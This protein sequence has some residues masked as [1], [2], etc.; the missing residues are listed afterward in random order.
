MELQYI[1]TTG[2]NE[3]FIA[4]TKLLDDFVI[5]YDKEE[6]D[7]FA[8]FNGS[9]AIQYALVVYYNNK[10]IGCG[11]IKQYNNTTFEIKRMFVMD[12]YRGKSI[13]VNILQ[14]LEDWATTMKGT[15]C[16]LETAIEFTSAQV[17]YKKMGYKIIPNY[18]Q[19]IGVE[20]SI[21]FEKVL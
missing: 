11:A 3:D 21:C 5:L 8:Q 1:K 17:L 18:G 20:R 2:T 4:L 14:Q 15:H 19:Y 13:A 9:H 10:P 7:F 16:I 6:F 12:E